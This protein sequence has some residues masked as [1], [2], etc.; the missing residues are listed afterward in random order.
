VQF[1]KD[2]FYKD[3]T[4]PHR[5][6]LILNTS[7]WSEAECAEFIVQAVHRIESPAAGQPGKG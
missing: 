2:H 3:A 4:D 6:D 5:Y 1:V 7:R